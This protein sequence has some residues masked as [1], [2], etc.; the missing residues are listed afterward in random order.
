MGL[1][2]AWKRIQARTGE[3]FT[4]DGSRF[5]EADHLARIDRSVSSF[6]ELGTY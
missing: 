1:A 3:L 2:A 4:S 5:N 6:D